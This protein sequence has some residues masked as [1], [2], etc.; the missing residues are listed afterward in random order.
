MIPEGEYDMRI[1][2]GA[3]AAVWMLVILNPLYLHLKR[4]PHK[5]AAIVVKALC[6]LSAAGLGLAGC[7]RGGGTADWW[8]LTGLLLC[9]LGDV[10]LCLHFVGGMGAFLLGHLAYV[11]AFLRLAPPSLWSLVIFILLAGGM[12]W[13]FLPSVPKMKRD[14]PAFCV[15]GGVIAAML[16]LAIPLCASMP[17]GEWLRGVATAGGAALFVFS[18]ILLA[19]NLFHASSKAADAVSLTAYY[20]GQLLLALSVYLFR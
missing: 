9:T 3:A 5:A 10:V 11:A 20:T 1:A 16:S 14:L 12:V 19:W 18:D 8:L 17:A 7:L 4:G 6:T 13:L 2:I 15:Y